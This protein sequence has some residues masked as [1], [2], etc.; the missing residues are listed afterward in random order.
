M[1]LVIALT[2]CGRI[3]F[4]PTGD[5]GGVSTPSFAGAVRFGDGAD[6]WGGALAT[7]SQGN[8]YVTGLFAGT[9]DFGDGPHP[10]AGAGDAY[11]ASFDPS[12]RLR[13]AKVFG[14]AGS[15]LGRAIRI[16]AA[17]NVYVVGDFEGA[18]D[19]GG[20]AITSAGADDGFVA[21]FTADG[22]YRWTARLGGVGD[23]AGNDIALT[24]GALLVTGFYVGSVDFG[25]GVRTS[26]GGK[27]LYVCALAPA[28][29][30][31]LW[32]RSFG[33]AGD[34]EGTNIG[35]DAA[36]RFDV[37]AT[38]N[39]ASFGTGAAY[40][41]SVL[42]SFAAD[43]T[44]RWVRPIGGMNNGVGAALAVL[45]TGEA[46]ITGR[47]ANTLATTNAT[48]TSAGGDDVFVLDLASDG[49]DTRALRFGSTGTDWGRA[50]AVDADGRLYITGHFEGEVAD[51]LGLAS[52]GSSDIFVVSESQT[53]DLNWALRLGGPDG[54]EGLAIAVDRDAI[55]L[56]GR[57]R[58]SADFGG[59]ELTSSGGTD[60]FL[61][62]LAR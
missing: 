15:D 32:S 54:D 22:A 55:F 38:V 41:G 17:D 43:Q 45:P 49:S 16:D 11:L 48:L 9:V 56:S 50:A 18:V 29:G 19:F 12:L 37:G 62:K 60:I 4:D 52:A 30:S 5:A 42:A 27:D 44:T 7:D 40:T 28:T 8:V 34:D 6:Q 51:G 53:L 25:D 1:G 35:A 20:G 26:A 39:G 31:V 23:D 13:W 10:E 57:L 2:G 59:G 24:S 36:D 3:A 61:L 47:F 33:G 14:A 46:R 58:G 21:S